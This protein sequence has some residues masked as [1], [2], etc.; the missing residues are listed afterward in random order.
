VAGLDQHHEHPRER[1]TRPR[2]G[3]RCH[4]YFLAS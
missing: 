3:A 2:N 1:R 4:A